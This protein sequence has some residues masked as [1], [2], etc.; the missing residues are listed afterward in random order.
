MPSTI[1]HLAV[2]GDEDLVNGLRLAG[3]TRHYMIPDDDLLAEEVRTAFSILMQDADIGIIAL[4]EKYV[5]YVNDLILK[6]KESKSLTPII[7]EVPSK[8][9]TD[10]RDVP[11]YYKD[12]VR[13]F[14]GFSVEI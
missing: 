8:Y 6:I 13:I 1:L 2:I 14:T 11:K 10:Y 5:E 4:Q 9:G 3:V 7:V 12:Y